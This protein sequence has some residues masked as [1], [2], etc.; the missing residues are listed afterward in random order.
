MKPS[1]DTNSTNFHEFPKPFSNSCQSVKFVS[2][3][4]RSDIGGRIQFE[5]NFPTNTVFKER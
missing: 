2:S 4:H 1:K 5:S 3:P